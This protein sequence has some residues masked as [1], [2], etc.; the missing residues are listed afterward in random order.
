MIVGGVDLTGACQWQKLK[1]KTQVSC[2]IKIQTSAPIMKRINMCTVCH[3]YCIQED[4]KKKKKNVGFFLHQCR[5]FP[6]ALGVLVAQWLLW[7]PASAPKKV[8][9]FRFILLKY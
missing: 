4:L 8:I 6:V 5:P 9:K 1:N 3:R 7:D 2:S